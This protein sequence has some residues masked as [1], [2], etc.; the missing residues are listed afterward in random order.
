MDKGS[1]IDS[2]LLAWR[3]RVLNIILS[4]AAL[5]ILPGL[6][7]VLI[8]AVGAPSQAGTAVAFVILYLFLLILVVFRRLGVQV[9]GWGLLLL[10]YGAGFVGLARL[11]LAG[12][13]RLYLMAAPI[14]ALILLGVRGGLIATAITAVVLAGMAALAQVGILEDWLT[15]SD[16]PLSLDMWLKSWVTQVMLLLVIVVLLSLLYRFQ[17][18]TLKAEHRAALDL[19]KAQALLEQHSQTLETQV[20]VRTQKL[21]EAENQIIE[22][23][24]AAL[25]KLSSPVIPVMDGIIILPLIGSIDAERAGDITRALLA[26]IN[27]YHAEVIIID[28][29]GVSVIDSEVAGYLNRTVKVVRLKGVRPVITGISDAVAETIVAL[30]IDWQD[31]DTLADLQTGLLVAIRQLGITLNGR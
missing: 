16:N 21:R 30:G 15:A 14:L 29:T 6:I 4:V 5:A 28:V 22:A 3:V 13:G 24:R 19:A 7:I 26:G 17:M 11:G 20:E 23:Q 10:A 31:M 25:R 12:D 18:R 8:Q 2:A 27:E 1:T 9:R